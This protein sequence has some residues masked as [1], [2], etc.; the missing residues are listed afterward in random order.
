M[1]FVDYSHLRFLSVF[2][3][4]KDTPISGYEHCHIEEIRN[5][6]EIVW[7]SIKLIKFISIKVYLD[8]ESLIA[9]CKLIYP[10]SNFAGCKT[11]F[12]SKI[13]LQ[14]CYNIVI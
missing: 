2:W 4:L 3:S 6:L 9:V 12:F 10:W 1:K 7:S 14:Y 5:H 11:P 13:W 8:L